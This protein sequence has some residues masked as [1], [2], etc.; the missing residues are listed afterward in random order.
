MG[1]RL[2]SSLA[3]ALLCLGCEQDPSVG[4]TCEFSSECAAP[5][6]CHMGRCRSECTVHRDCPLQA[7]CVRLGEIGRCTLESDACTADADCGAGLVCREA[8]CWN[9]CADQPC[10]AGGECVDALCR[11]APDSD[12]GGSD[13]GRSD[14]GEG[15]ADAGNMDAGNTDAGNTDAGSADG[16]VFGP[17]TFPAHEACS[18]GT[19]T[20]TG[21]RTCVTDRS[22]EPACLLACADD[23]GCPSGAPC[24]YAH[25]TTDGFC[26]EGCNPVTGDGCARGDACDWI[27]RSVPGMPSAFRFW[28]CRAA[29]PSTAEGTPCTAG[30]PSSCPAGFSC[31]FAEGM[32]RC[33]RHCPVIAD[34]SPWCGAG[35]TCRAWS[36][37]TPV[38]GV[39][40]GRCDPVALP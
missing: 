6:V 12:A 36:S 17:P 38:S 11:L 10:Q 1:L 5:L 35:R 3:L 28:G 22:A 7:R 4:A 13:A 29:T 15:S 30:T 16:G 32:S 18:A 39:T 33:V 19:P 21:D 27:E 8:Q 25:R 2:V 24:V 31:S 34:S 26:A 37:A 14:A 9:S 20:C 23:S 40:I